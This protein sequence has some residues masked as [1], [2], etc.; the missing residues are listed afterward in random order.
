MLLLLFLKD[1]FLYLCDFGTE[2]FPLF[3]YLSDFQSYNRFHFLCQTVCLG[4]LFTSR[5]KSLQGSTSVQNE[6]WSEK[7]PWSQSKTDLT[8][9]VNKVEESLNILMAIGCL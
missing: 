4:I 5:E 7:Q 6:S 8:L 9:P 1:I 2:I 3:S